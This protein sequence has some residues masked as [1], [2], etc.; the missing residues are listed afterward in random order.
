MRAFSFRWVAALPLL[1][2]LG[3][4]VVAAPPPAASLN[5][6]GAAGTSYEIARPTLRRDRTP[7]TFGPYQPSEVHRGWAA[8]DEHAEPLR[9][10]YSQY[11]VTENSK[12]SFHF[13]DGQGH[14]AT[15]YSGT[16]A[17]TR[18]VAA[19]GGRQPGVAPRTAV[20]GTALI[21]G[22]PLGGT[23]TWHLLLNTP[24][25]TQPGAAYAPAEVGLLTDE[26]QVQLRI[27]RV[28]RGGYPPTANFE[29]LHQEQLVGY[30]DFSTTRPTVWLRNDLAPD[31]RF[32]TATVI[33]AIFVQ[34]DMLPLY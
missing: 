8:V 32:L 11:T 6:F 3:G 9:G 10:P 26:Q 12:V 31:L 28:P 4:C 23:T 15:V 5:P 2:A 29:L 25:P 22:A 17:V 27:R 24:S 16:Q 34:D 20:V 21:V 33:S 1:A 13:A 18:G 7:A 30:L 19:G 14:E